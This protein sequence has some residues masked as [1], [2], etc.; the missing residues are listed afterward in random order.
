MR[1]SDA[2]CLRRGERVTE[3]GSPEKLPCDEYAALLAMVE[4][5]FDVHT[6]ARGDLDRF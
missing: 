1:A 5:V 4:K 3:K 6:Q 2:D